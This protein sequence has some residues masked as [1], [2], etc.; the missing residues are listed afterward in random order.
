MTIKYLRI[1][2]ENV[3][4]LVQFNLHK[5]P[6]S[7]QKTIEISEIKP[8]KLEPTQNHRKKYKW[9]M[10][11]RAWTIDE[12]EVLKNYYERYSRKGRMPPNSIVNLAR[13]LKR[14][15]LAVSAKAKAEG[16]THIADR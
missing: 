16:F 8:D 10:P 2:F 6:L 14:T 3:D 4:E 5:K 11:W 1:D 13:K 7:E 9:S 12:L 15:A